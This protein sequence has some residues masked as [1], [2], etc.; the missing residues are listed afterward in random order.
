VFGSRK[1][2]FGFYLKCPGV[3]VWG[4]PLVGVRESNGTL[5]FYI[6]AILSV[7]Q[8]M[9]EVSLW[10]VLGSRQGHFGFYLKCPGVNVWGVPLVGVRESAGTFWFYIHAIVSVLRL[11]FEV[12]LWLVFGSRKGHFGFYIKCPGVNV[13]GVPSVGV[14]ESKGTLVRAICALNCPINHV[15]GFHQ[16]L[17]M[18]CVLLFVMGI[19]SRCMVR[20]IC[21][22]FNI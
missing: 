11:M 19:P 3:N 22:R 7:L 15:D 16:R 4:A 5:C 13:W 2:H 17:R 14:R 6:H 18:L 8:L 1:G 12:S 20:S 21:L 9:F 10:L